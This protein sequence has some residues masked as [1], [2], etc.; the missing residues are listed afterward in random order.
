MIARLVRYVAIRSLSRAEDAL[1]DAICAD[2]AAEGLRAERRGNNVWCAVGDAPRPRLLLN[3]HLD[4]VPPGAGW[5]HDPWEP[6]LE[7]GRLSGLGAN[8]AKGCVVALL[9]AFLALY[10]ALR[11]GAALGG[12][13]V[14]ALTAE[15]ET[16]GAGLGT[17]RDALAPLDAA[18]VGEPT[19]LLPLTAQRGLLILRCVARGT[20]AHPANT[21]PAAADNAI[22]HAVEDVQRLRTFDW[23]P[24]HPLLG[25]CHGHVTMLQG[26][27]ARNVIPDECEF[28]LD[29]RTTPAE[30]HQALTTRLRAALRSAVHVHSERLG[31]VET[32]A[33]ADIVQAACA[34]LPGVR[35]AGSPAMSDMVFL[36]DVPAVKIGP[37]DTRRSHTPNEYLT[38]DELTAGA[39][40]YE[41][42]ARA[43]FART[44]SAGPALRATPG[45]VA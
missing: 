14:L 42:I 45:A 25:R 16:S 39:A 19:A 7:G 3:S 18:L 44:G 17:I 6:Q 24:T 12:T 1:A 4:T 34:A 38:V 31:P 30:S 5:R 22:V 36:P 33:A 35:P 32:P 41:R 11:A 27:V 15:E 10:R 13:V 8:D 2:L 20:T 21:E 43:Y 28:F 37:G 40:A 26:G 9:E 29:I 23:G